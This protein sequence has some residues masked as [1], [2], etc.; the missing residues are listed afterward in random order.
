MEKQSDQ[1]NQINNQEEQYFQDKAAIEKLIKE[2]NLEEA[3]KVLDK[4]VKKY[5]NKAEIFDLYSEVLISLNY[6]KEAKI[7]IETS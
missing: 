2:L 7:A 3:K 4:A 5:S 6:T 1:T